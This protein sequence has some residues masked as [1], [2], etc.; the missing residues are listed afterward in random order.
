M[1]NKLICILKRLVIPLAF[2]LGL[3]QILTTVI[4]NRF[5]LPGIPDTLTALAAL[6]TESD[7]YSAV[8]LSLCRV[9][10]GL[11]LGIFSGAL[12]AFL[13]HRYELPRSIFTPIISIIKSTPVAS[14]IVVLWVLMS[15]DALSVFIGFLMVMPL[16]YQNIFGGLDAIDKGLTEVADVFEF[17]RTKRFRLLTLPTLMSYFLPALTNAVGLCWKAVI[18][19]EII[20]YTKRSI[21]QGI[22][23]AKYDMDTP[24]VFAWTLLI[25]IFSLLLE[26][27]VSLLTRRWKRNA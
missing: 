5:L 1:K 18:A 19:A 13:C 11:L 26:W 15:G 3:W 16:I 10:T 23:D 21:G 12:L 8:L 24:T 27:T 4:G 6:L 2:W 14:F 20:A 22:N 7:F 9:I 17:S 25:I